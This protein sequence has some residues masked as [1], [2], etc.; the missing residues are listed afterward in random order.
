M[1]ESNAVSTPVDCGIKLSRYDEGSNVDATY[2][3]SLVG[4]LRYLT[5]IRSDILYGVKL[6][7][8]YIKKPKS[9]H[10]MA[11]KR[12]MCYIKRTICYGLLY[13]R[14]DDF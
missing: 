12:I 3:K 11:A 13:T 2:F 7:S 6:V 8:H 5:C 10:L 1:E 9:T 4:S 14:C